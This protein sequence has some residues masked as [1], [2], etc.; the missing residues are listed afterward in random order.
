M[1]PEFWQTRWQNHQIGF[2]QAAVNPLLIEHF[3]ALDLSAHSQILVPLC[4]KSIDMTWLVAQG[5]DV[6]GIELSEIA[7]QEFFAEQKITPT[8][9]KHANNPA[10]KYYQ[11]CLANQTV[12]QTITLWVADIFAL[13]A[14]DL[15]PIDAIYDRAA[16]IALPA[17]M[18]SR[19]SKQLSQ[20]SGHDSH[21]NDKNVPQLL[22]TLNY[23]QSERGN[24]PPFAVSG[25]QVQKYY[26][27]RYQINELASKPATIGSAPD[28]QVTEHVWLLE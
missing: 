17:E 4:G 25:E 20:L 23:D 9:H 13:T 1:T 18:R 24:K 27:D 5:H 12:E 7:V 10:I 2:H 21:S 14:K 16:L 19:Y 26:G 8:I 3:N 15:G 11:G 6:V 28:L 22:I